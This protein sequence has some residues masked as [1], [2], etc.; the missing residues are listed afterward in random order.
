[1][2]FEKV[3]QPSFLLLSAE[4]DSYVILTCG[5]YQKGKKDR[6]SANKVMS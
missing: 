3:L 6:G 2:H 4:Q 1:M 5:F